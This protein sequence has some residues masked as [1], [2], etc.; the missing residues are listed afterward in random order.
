MAL[1]KA[2]YTVGIIFVVLVLY[3]LPIQHA[4][5]HFEHF[6]HYNNSGD[7]I[8]KYFVYQQVMPE[9]T[10]PGESSQI[11]FSIQD[12]NNNDISSVKVMIEI[13]SSD[14][15]PL[16]IF[17]WRE[18]KT[19]DFGV[20]YTF[21]KKGTYQIVLSIANNLK[22]DVGIQNFER[23]ILTD[24]SGCLCDRGIFN[25]AVSQNFGNVYKSTLILAIIL[26]L[27]ILGLILTSK[28]RGNK[29]TLQQHNSVDKRN[30]PKYVIMLLALAGGIIHLT[31]YSEHSSLRLE[32]SI[33][34]IAA[35]GAQIA[36]GS[37][38]IFTTLE[39]M[40]KVNFKS[41]FSLLSY[42][43]KTVRIN[44]FGLAGTVVLV[45]LYSYTIFFP[46]PLSP[47]NEP[48]TIEP[49]GILAKTVEILL[50]IGIVYLM[51]WE[52]LQKNIEML[53]IQK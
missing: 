22:G 15:Q 33:F 30:F 12:R 2:R 39:Y 52:K 25:V 28:F 44:L 32:Y 8:G 40:N 43:N 46:P 20:N 3:V 42:Y 13:Y 49:A 50:I 4:S 48:D 24:T 29:K 51:R 7:E 11:L 34:L 5:S 18:Y 45:V 23:N 27:V 14:G 1:V 21:E 47:N 41:K 19:G 35:G 16:K 10:K 9:Y 37:L 38:Y 31:V 26:P 17:P 6:T 36:Y 53:R